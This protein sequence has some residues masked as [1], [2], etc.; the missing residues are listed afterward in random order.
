M[1][2]RGLVRSSRHRENLV[3]MIESN[4]KHDCGIESPDNRHG[5]GDAVANP[6]GP[7]SSCAT[8]KE[9]RELRLLQRK[10]G[11]GSEDSGVCG[12]GFNVHTQRHPADKC[13]GI[14]D[15]HAS[16]EDSSCGGRKWRNLPR[17]YGRLA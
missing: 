6:G 13:R 7:A 2:F 11:L 1:A 16:L 10:M 14:A 12:V 15:Q 17:K 8:A 3:L 9:K 4:E 5:N